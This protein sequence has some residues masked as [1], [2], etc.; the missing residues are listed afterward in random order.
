MKVMWLAMLAVATTS[1]CLGSQRAAP[2]PDLEVEIVAIRD[3]LGRY[4]PA[5]LTVDDEYV[6]EGHAPPPGSGQRRPAKR[7]QALSDSL[8]RDATNPRGDTLRIRASV[9]QLRGQSASVHVTVDGRLPGGHRPAFYETVAIV[10][11]RVGSRWIVRER[12]QLGIS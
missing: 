7:H 4:R 5:V 6:E 12:T 10:L 9:P 1:A 11:E 8:R 2:D 3:V